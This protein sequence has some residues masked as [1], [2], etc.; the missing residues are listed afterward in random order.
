MTIPI[1]RVQSAIRFEK[2][3]PKGL[4]GLTEQLDMGLADLLEGMALHCFQGK[5]PFSQQTSLKIEQLKALYDLDL[6][7][8]DSHVMQETDLPQSS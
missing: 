3:L 4:K 8:S 6:T 5:Q 1:E 7:A 2:R